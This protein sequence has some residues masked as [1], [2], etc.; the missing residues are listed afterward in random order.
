MTR[1]SVCCHN[2]HGYIMMDHKKFPFRNVQKFDEN[3]PEKNQC[4]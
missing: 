1:G 2:L 4:V 3:R